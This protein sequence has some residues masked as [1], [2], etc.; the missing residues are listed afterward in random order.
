MRQLTIG[1]SWLLIMVLVIQMALPVPS[2]RAELDAKPPEHGEWVLVSQREH[3]IHINSNQEDYLS[4]HIRLQASIDLS[5]YDWLPFGGNDKPAFTGVFDGNGYLVSGVS[6]TGND[7]EAAGF[8]GSS[9]GVI[10]NLGVEGHIH[11]GA[12]AGILAGIIQ[13][14]SIDR[15]YSIGSVESGTFPAAGVSVAGGLVGSAN[16]STITRAYS[17]ADVVAG[18]TGNMYAGGLVGSLGNGSIED[19]YAMGS[20]SNRIHSGSFALR[21]A[22]LTSFMIHGTVQRTYATGPIDQTA[23]TG[24]FFALYGGLTGD[25]F[26]GGGIQQSYFDTD[27]TGTATGV[28]QGSTSGAI[29]KVTAEMHLQSTYVDWDFSAIWAIH[30]DVN[31][32]YPYLRPAVLTEVLPQAAK[33]EPYEVQLSAFDGAGGGL[34]WS[35]AGLPD[36]MELSASGMLHGTPET[37]GSF[38]IHV[39]AEDIGSGTAEATLQLEVTEQAP[40]IASFEV[41]PGA[42]IGSV[43]ASGELI[44]PTHRLVYLLSAE[45]HARPLVGDHAPAE[46]SPYTP[47]DDIAGAAA[48][49]YLSLYETDESGL[50]RAWSVVQLEASHIRAAIP[51]TGIRVEP[52]ELT[53]TAGDPPQRVTAVIE[54]ADADNQAVSWSSDTPGVATVNVSGEIT[55]LAPGTATVTAQAAD[56]GH[57]AEVTVTVQARP[58]VTG[59]I[60]GTVY[61]SGGTPLSGAAVTVN[62]ESMAVTASD[63]T[64][65]ITDLSAAAVTIQIS[66]PGY[67][68]FTREVD[69]PAGSTL[70]LG[71]IVLARSQT[72]GGWIYYPP[73]LP[74]EP[75]PQSTTVVSVNG[76]D[77]Q[78][79]LTSNQA[80]DG[81]YAAT[82]TFDETQVLA[83]L[84][85]QEAGG[86]AV[87]DMNLTESIVLAELPASALRRSWL[88]HPNGTIELRVNGAGITLPLALVSQHTSS[89]I[90]TIRIARL[91]DE[92]EDA[93]QHALSRQGMRSLSEIVEL[94]ILLDG[95]AAAA[96][97]DGYIAHSI[98]VDAPVDGQRISV[99]R[100]AEGQRL[101]RT[102]ARMSQDGSDPIAFFSLQPGLFTVV[103]SVPVYSGWQ[104]HWAGT[105][106]GVLTGTRIWEIDKEG[107]VAPD[108]PI[109]RATFATLLVRTLGIPEMTGP[110]GFA[111]VEEADP[112]I[113]IYTAA[114]EAGL[115]GGYEDGS[116]RPETPV[117]REQMAV[118]TVRALA[119]ARQ[120]GS[121]AGLTAIAGAEQAA[122]A[123]FTDAGDIAVWAREPI[124]QLTTAGIVVGSPD[125]AFAPKQPATNAQAAVML[126]RMLQHLELS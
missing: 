7:L 12:N 48:G 112:N 59:S 11:G 53:L 91:T 80:A 114:R 103:E 37:A 32:G 82:L 61:A 9:S 71:R 118:M 15:S 20:V 84:D 29:A 43:A 107:S 97:D 47:G 57:T 93:A 51:V 5:G 105:D 88:A 70:E 95:I 66:A 26:G 101:Y 83:M 30:P 58:P 79:K 60:A 75:Q 106:I 25:V 81:R 45:A 55:P 24:A 120:R 121:A 85:D 67:E 110:H 111:D 40:D 17:T 36:G 99:V 19:A 33:G 73:V 31:G 64:F 16:N 38:A 124:A 13:G 113:G 10:R 44:E 63:G 94:S 122:A 35:A 52:T 98:A 77:I 92:D 116:F 1:S 96:Y 21:S 123:R 28:A 125:G 89:E 46:A 109:S 68:P 65:Q 62:G 87:I 108:A 54:P 76:A 39:T 18:P 27:T 72:G 23:N 115:I 4:A 22:G 41:Y 119:F 50:I 8:F 49:Q 126:R 117:T 90:V 74:P 34:T 6:V 104:G 3:L 102:P 78:V 86:H 2:A 14:G 69:V 56:G 42:V 100:I